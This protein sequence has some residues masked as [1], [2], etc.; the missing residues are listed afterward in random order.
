MSRSCDALRLR[1]VI[2][3]PS[4]DHAA[5]GRRMPLVNVLH[6]NSYT[7]AS[8]P[9][10]T[11]DRKRRRRGTKGDTLSGAHSPTAHSQ[12]I[13]GALKPRGAWFA[14]AASP[15]DGRSSSGAAT[16]ACRA[17]PPRVGRTLI[18][19]ERRRG[20]Y[21]NPAPWATSCEQ[22]RLALAGSLQ[23]TEM[24]TERRCREVLRACDWRRSRR[25]DRARRFRWSRRVR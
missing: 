5:P 17:R 20:T 12:D 24:R 19:V 22:L 10:A 9:L 13:L 25:G 7:V 4:Q 1:P 16:G 15:T 11:R 14:A 3:R 23:S 6:T 2:S 18:C 8:R 21:E